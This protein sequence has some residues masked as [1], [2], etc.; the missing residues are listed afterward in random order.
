MG[1]VL[2]IVQL[3]A[4][5]VYATCGLHAFRACGMITR[6]SS[7]GA[8]CYFLTAAVYLAGAVVLGLGVSWWG[9]AAII[10]ATA[11]AWGARAAAAR[12]GLPHDAFEP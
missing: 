4:A 9:L 7:A 12:A 10:P 1:I 3:F 5:L 11:L 2:R 6:V 8:V